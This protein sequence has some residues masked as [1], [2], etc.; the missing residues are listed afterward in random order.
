MRRRL[1]V[2]VGLSVAARLA[3]VAAAANTINLSD[4]FDPVKTKMAGGATGNIVVLGDSISFRE[5]SYLPVFTQLMQTT[6]GNAGP[7]YQSISTGGN[8]GVFS[9]TW[10]YGLVNGDNAP[11][12]SLD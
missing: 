5:G 4:A 8:A 10:D 7:G 2:V 1:C 6:Y 9:G 11:H 3:A 12:N